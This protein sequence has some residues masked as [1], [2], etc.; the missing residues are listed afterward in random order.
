M[1]SNETTMTLDLDNLSA[2]DQL[3]WDT[4]S[5]ISDVSKDLNGVRTRFDWSK[6]TQQA[7]DNYLDKLQAQLDR[8]IEE[9][10]EAERQAAIQL[11]KNIQTVIECGAG[12]RETA[13][14][15]IQEAELEGVTI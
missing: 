1:L 7:L 8:E 14:R 2:A 11:E 10:R 12:D 13:L 3:R 4:Y 5:M 6:W 9:E 15:W